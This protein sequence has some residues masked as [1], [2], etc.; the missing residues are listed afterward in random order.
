MSLSTSPVR[1]RTSGQPVQEPGVAG[2][3]AESLRVEGSGP[4][5]GREGLL[6]SSRWRR[7]GRPGRHRRPP[8]RRRRRVG[9]SGVGRDRLQLPVEVQRRLQQLVAEGPE[10]RLLQEHVLAR[11]RC[12]TSGSRPA[13]GRTEP[14]PAGVRGAR[15]VGRAELPVGLPLHRD[16]RRQAD[17]G[18]HDRRH[19]GREPGAMPPEPSACPR[20]RR[21]PAR[22]TPAPRR[23]NARRPRPGPSPRDSG[24][25][26]ASAIAFRQ[27]ASRAARHGPVDRH[28]AAG[29]LPAGPRSTRRRP[30]GPRRA[31]ARSGG[32]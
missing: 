29:T 8:G 3:G 28:A 10:L 11:P 27:T 14:G 5:E 12:G 32:S 18:H 13:P 1:S 2:V 26:A 30:R 4:P 7:R 22:P 20:R 15:A 17:Q 23:A 25:R 19:A 6:L 21:A 9:V 31:A 16:H 24:P